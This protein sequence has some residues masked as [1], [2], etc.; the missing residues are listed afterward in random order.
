MN[1]IPRLLYAL[2][3][4]SALA[5]RDSYAQSLQHIKLTD[6]SGALDLSDYIIEANGFVPVPVLITEPALGGFGGGFVPVFINKR[7]PYID[8]VKGHVVRTP[9]P[10]DITGAM[11]LYTANNT[12]MAGAFR[13]GTFIKP[14]IKY[15]AGGGYA[16]VN[17][18]FY[19][20][21]P[22][23]GEKQFSFNIKG[24]GVLLQ[25]TKRIA[26][27]HWYIG[28]KYFLLHSDVSYTGDKIL[29]PVFVRPSEYDVLISQLGA[30]LELD[31]RDN[32]FTPDNGAKIH[33]DALCSNGVLGSDFDYWRSNYYGYIYR[34]LLPRLT[35]GLRI[36]G[37]QVY[38]DAPFFLLPYIDLRG[39]P[40]NR[41]QGKADIL[42][43]AELRWD[44]RYRWSAM[45]YG[46]TGKAFNE[47]SDFGASEWVYSYGTGF[48]YLLASKFKL[49][50][51]VDIAGGPD[52]WAYYI[53][54]GSNWLK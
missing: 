15:L 16:N 54:F 23:L 17:M 3:L 29:P 46:G 2:L 13:S 5:S 7:P 52:S 45:L 11:G 21:L 6:S 31:S 8:S 26:L 1:Q 37:Q 4:L 12:W 36:D 38:G 40:A 27:S 43:E 30:L 48:R 53:V 35:G 25:A 44:F 47:W 41:Y 19:K 42:T 18:A 34:Q 33:I 9:V 39:I 49:R 51:G 28:L 24:Y 22:G 32:I 10:P 20:T 50:V 14:R